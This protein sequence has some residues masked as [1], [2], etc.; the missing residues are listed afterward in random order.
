MKYNGAMILIGALPLLVAMAVYSY[1]LI[2]PNIT[3]FQHPWWVAFR[4]WAVYLGY[5]RRD[6]SWITYLVLVVVFFVFHFIALRSYKT[7]PVLKYAVLVGGILLFSYPFLSHDFFNYM[8]DARILT[9]HGKNPYLFKA[10]DFPGDQWTRFM[11]WTHRPYPYGP[12]FLPI[13]LIPSALGFG[14]FSL[15]FFLFKAVWIGMYIASVYFLRTMNKRAAVFFATHPYIIIEGLVNGHNDLIGVALALI[16][17]WYVFKND[18]IPAF[19][20]FIFSLC[21]KYV[22]APVLLIDFMHSRKLMRT[23]FVLQ[24]ALILAL[25]YKMG[26]QQWY[27]LSLFVFVPFVPRLMDKLHVFFAGL[28]FSYY[29]YIRLGGWDSIEKVDLKNQI[30]LAFSMVQAVYLFAYYFFH[31]KLHRK[32]LRR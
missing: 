32:F 26:V 16:G 4:D 24:V 2:D 20:A 25:V 7:F 31:R 10:L 12:T 18:K 28:L 3:F 8:F 30:I 1:F 6:I 17:V 11:H 13:T 29:P 22:T 19:I 14:K 9:H 23:V 21:I 15:T 5:Y 27:F